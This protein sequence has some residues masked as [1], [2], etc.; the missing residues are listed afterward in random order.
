[1]EVIIPQKNK[2]KAIDF[3]CS[4][5]GMTHGFKSAGIN[6]LAGIDIDHSCKETYEYNNKGSIFIE[7]DIKN[8]SFKEL[9]KETGIKIND[10]ELIFIGCSPCQ[11]WSIIKTNKTK[12]VETKNLLTDFQRFVEYFKPGFVVVENVPGILKTRK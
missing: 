9:K 7:A 11:Y 6:V 3:F 2:L 5:G 10:D 4:I 8:Y 12:S 1:M